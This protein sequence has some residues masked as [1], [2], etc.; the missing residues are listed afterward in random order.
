MWIFMVFPRSSKKGPGKVRFDVHDPLAYFPY[1]LIK[2]LFP[3]LHAH[4]LVSYA[5]VCILLQE[6][7]L[8]R[9][10]YDTS[11]GEDKPR[12]GDVL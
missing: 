5:P 12:T 11:L 1:I 7:A 10:Q 2:L 9:R 4:V 6:I 3:K 8:V